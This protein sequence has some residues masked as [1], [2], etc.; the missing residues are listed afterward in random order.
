MDYEELIKEQFIILLNCSGTHKHAAKK[1][2]SIIA[3]HINK[4]ESLIS[5]L[6]KNSN[7]NYDDELTFCVDLL[8]LHGYTYEEVRTRTNDVFLR[9]FSDK[10]TGNSRY[11]SRK[12]SLEIISRFSASFNCFQI[13]YDRKPET[14][15]ELRNYMLHTE[16]VL[17]EKHKQEIKQLENDYILNRK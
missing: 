16:D 13:D 4:Q 12:I 5:K 2:I 8:K 7:K 1:A 11:N 14:Y 10:V 6:K 3:S 15:E 17:E 9:W